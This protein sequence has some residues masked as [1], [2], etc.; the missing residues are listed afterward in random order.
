MVQGE[1]KVSRLRHR[2]ELSGRGP[3]N[4]STLVDGAR[5]ECDF[6]HF[7]PM[8]VTLHIDGSNSRHICKQPFKLSREVR[9]RMTASFERASSTGNKLQPAVEKPTTG[10]CVGIGSN[11]RKWGGQGLA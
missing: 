6:H 2:Q 7:L 4:E 3:T 10:E 9:S 1:R 11:E 5:N 8:M